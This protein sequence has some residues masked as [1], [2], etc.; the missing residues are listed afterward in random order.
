MYATVIYLCYLKSVLRYKFLILN[1]NHLDNLYLFEQECEDA[2][3][4]FK[5]KKGPQA[6]K[7]GKHWIIC[8]YAVA[9]PASIYQHIE[10]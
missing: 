7:Y 5:A 6:K 4:F 9:K 1:T 2:W 8:L 10:F 3:L